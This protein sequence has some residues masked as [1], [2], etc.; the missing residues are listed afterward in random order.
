MTI[1]CENRRTSNN[2][3]LNKHETFL[4]TLEENKNKYKIKYMV[5]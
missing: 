5:T 4:D 3:K 2:K 1:K